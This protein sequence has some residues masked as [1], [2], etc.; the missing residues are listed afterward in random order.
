MT[1]ATTRIHGTVR[2]LVFL[3]MTL[4][5]MTPTGALAQSIP[6]LVAAW[7]WVFVHSFREIPTAMILAYPGTEPVGI[8]M[9]KYWE[10]STYQ[11]L[12]AF[13]VML[14]SVLLVT[15]LVAMRIGKRFGIRDV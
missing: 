7:I 5:A 11:R 2:V 8:V 9:F 1:R 4:M 10:D 14:F 6:G 3:A 15:S 13:G 12:A